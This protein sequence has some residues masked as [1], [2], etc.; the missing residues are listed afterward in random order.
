MFKAFKRSS[1]N[2]ER[3]PVTDQKR[4]EKLFI[5]VMIALVWC[6]KIGDYVDENKKPIK[7]KKHQR[8]SFSVFKYGLNCINNTLITKYQSVTIFVM[9]LEI[10]VK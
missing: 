7:I 9:Y 6:C 2:I 1:F 4:L 8:R 3:T 5:V 10:F